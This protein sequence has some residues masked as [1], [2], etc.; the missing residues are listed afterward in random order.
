MHA[1]QPYANLGWVGGGRESNRVIGASGDPVIGRSTPG[2]ESGK[3]LF[4]GV[5]VGEGADGFAIEV[6]HSRQK[7]PLFQ[8]DGLKRGGL[9]PQLP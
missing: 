7:R 8:D 1:S 3:S 2:V 4:L 9:A 6:L 5:E